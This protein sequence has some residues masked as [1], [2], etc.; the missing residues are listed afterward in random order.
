VDQ[1]KIGWF[2][3]ELRK[4]K[5]MTQEQIA[6]QFNVS[7]RTVSR[8]ENGYNMP[9]LD[10]LIE[11]SDYYEIDLRELLNGERKSEEMNKEMKETVLKAVD[12]TNTEAEKYNKRVRIFNLIAMLLMVAYMSL[13]DTGIYADNQI[14]RNGLDFAQ[15]LSVGMLLCGVIMSSRYGAKV[16]A[17]KQRLLKKSNI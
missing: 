15:G 8:W 2:L 11:I 13:R 4:E 14:I 17:F 1:K 7:S 16:R 6:E 5:E 12:Y 10:I 9:D 3:K